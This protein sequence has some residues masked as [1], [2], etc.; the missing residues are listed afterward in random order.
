[1]KARVLSVSGST[2]EEPYGRLVKVPLIRLKGKWMEKMGFK[3][4]S[5]VEVTGK[6]GKI[7]LKIVDGG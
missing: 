6:K 2:Y 5:K 1:M 7:T 3:V 4:G